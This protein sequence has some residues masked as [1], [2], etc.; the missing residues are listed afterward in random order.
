MSERQTPSR[1]GAVSVDLDE[2]VEYLAIHGLTESAVDNPHVVYDVAVPRLLQ[3]A[4]ELSLPLTLFV[5]ARDLRRLAASQL[6]IEAHDAGHELGNHSLDHRYDLT[7]LS[8]V[9]QRH[10]VVE[11]QRLLTELTGRAPRGFRAPGY[12]CTDSLLYEVAKAGLGYDSS[13]FPCP[14]YYAAKAGVLLAQR[15]LGR[16]SRAVLDDPRVLL[17]QRTP[18]LRAIRQVGEA[19]RP[20]VELPIQVVTPLRLPFIGTSLTLAPSPVFRGLLRAAEQAASCNLELHGLDFLDA[21]DVPGPLGRVQPDL[22][23]PVRQKLERL[24]AVVRSQRARGTS[25][26]TLEAW[27]DQIRLV[28]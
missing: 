13:V 16:R 7:R 23:V 6:L 8:R 20:L 25:F 2:I 12:T 24:T 14:P 5:I 9:E 26:S 28:T 3:W 1:F 17:S 11:A 18:S 4:R 21:S 10:Q 19:T 22:R 15:A 27:A